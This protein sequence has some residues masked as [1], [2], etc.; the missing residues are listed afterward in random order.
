MNKNWKISN[1]FIDKTQ[2]LFGCFLFAKV[3]KIYCTCDVRLVKL[4]YIKDG[5]QVEM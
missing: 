1:P 3:L 5:Q 2:L 4:I